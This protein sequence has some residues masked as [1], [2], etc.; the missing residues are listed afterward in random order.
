MHPTEILSHLVFSN[1]KKFAITTD[2]D[3]ILESD[4]IFQP[5][6]MAV[7]EIFHNI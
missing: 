6:K 1:F 7:S 3:V 4:T 2:Y 5:R